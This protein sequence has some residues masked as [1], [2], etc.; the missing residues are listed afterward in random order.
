MFLFREENSNKRIRLDPAS[1]NNSKEVLIFVSFSSSIIKIFGN[2]SSII[3][4]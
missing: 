2:K 3:N 1:Q 4:N